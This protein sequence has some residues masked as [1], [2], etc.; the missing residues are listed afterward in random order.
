M[1]FEIA[2]VITD[3]AVGRA[4]ALVESVAG[5]FFE[6]VEDRVRFF[7]RDFVRLR[8]AFDKVLALLRHLFPVLFAHGA[9]EK[10]GLGK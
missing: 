10:I 2:R 5:K 8:A 1:R 9:P 7:L 6:Q 4:M 3:D